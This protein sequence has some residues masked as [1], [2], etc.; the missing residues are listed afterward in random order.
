MVRSLKIT[1]SL[2]I[3]ERPPAGYASVQNM[4]RTCPH[5]K[6]SSRFDEVEAQGECHRILISWVE[7]IL[8]LILTVLVRAPQHVAFDHIVGRDQTRAARISACDDE[9]EGDPQKT[10]LA[11]RGPITTRDLPRSRHTTPR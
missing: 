10:S 6:D 8:P 5:Q 1:L 4:R 2:R 11:G 7:A 3:N 9:R